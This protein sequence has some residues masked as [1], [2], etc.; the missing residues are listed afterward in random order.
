MDTQKE[1]TEAKNKLEK[2][3]SGIPK[4]ISKSD[5][6]DDP[7]FVENTCKSFEKAL[8]EAKKVVLLEALKDIE[9]GDNPKD[10]IRGHLASL[11]L[12]STLDVADEIIE[13]LDEEE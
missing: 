10:A 2:F 7:A 3:S 5:H 11:Q 8:T 9:S 13:K 12:D 1:L 4:A 6:G